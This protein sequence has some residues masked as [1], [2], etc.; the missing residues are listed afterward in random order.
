MILHFGAHPLQPD[1]NTVVREFIRRAQHVIPESLEWLECIDTAFLEQLPGTED[2]EYTEWW[3]YVKPHKGAIELPR[4]LITVVIGNFPDLLYR[5]SGDSELGFTATPSN[6][7]LTVC[8]RDR[9][10]D[11]ATVIAIQT[12]TTEP[13]TIIEVSSELEVLLALEEI[14]GDEV[15]ITKVH[16]HPKLS[17][18]AGLWAGRR[19]RQTR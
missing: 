2:P 14:A 16:P 12:S 5:R 19:R 8:I 9:E 13:E 4:S 18:R 3:T 6:H 17:R 1:H 11:G 15:T 7:P 10:Y